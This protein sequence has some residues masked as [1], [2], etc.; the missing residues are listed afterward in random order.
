[1]EPNITPKYVIR[2][3]DGRIYRKTFYRNK[4]YFEFGALII[5]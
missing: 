1:M 2:K 4:N 3:G 5:F